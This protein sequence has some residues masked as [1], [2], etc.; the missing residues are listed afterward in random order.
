MTTARDAATDTDSAA[1]VA[2][3]SHPVG[4]IE[5]QFHVRALLLPTALRTPVRGPPP[6]GDV[7][8]LKVRAH[9]NRAWQVLRAK[10]RNGQA[11][12]FVLKLLAQVGCLWGPICSRRLFI[13]SWA[14]QATFPRRFLTSSMVKLPVSPDVAAS[15][16]RSFGLAPV[17]VRAT[18]RYS[19]GHGAHPD[20]APMDVLR[21][22]LAARRK[23]RGRW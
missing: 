3:P 11:R 2:P 13:A 15:R 6:G 8:M 20:T 16:E 19:A 10:F 17:P 21:S 18:R 7:R 14:L 4:S 23:V 9:A 5:T 1:G 22:Y 12:P